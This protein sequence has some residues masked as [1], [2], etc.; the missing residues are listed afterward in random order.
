MN[1]NDILNIVTVAEEGS[2]TQASKKLFI[3]QSAIS[4]SVA[5][6]ERELGVQLFIR[7]RNE[8][9]KTKS[10]DIFVTNGAEVLR[11]YNRLLKDM[12]GAAESG[13]RKL[14][15]GTASFFFRFLTYHSEAVKKRKV[16]NFDF[17]IIEETAANIEK[18]VLNGSVD[19]CFTRF[20]LLN[21]GLEYEDLF[22]ETILIAVPA[23]HPIALKHPEDE[24]NR[25]P[26]LPLSDFKD[27]PFVMINNPRITPLCN[28]LCHDAGFEPNVTLRTGAWEHVYAYIKTGNAVGFI[29]CLHVDNSNKQVRFFRID[30]DNDYLKHVVAYTANAILPANARLYINEFRNFIA[31]RMPL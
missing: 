14:R 29:S 4:Q 2:F 30:S 3:S 21:T 18:M 10:C 5:K 1:I 26:I 12:K 8:I 9:H 25:F 31:E 11:S 19:F 6:V 17:E 20:P 16:F 15:I 24:K 27:E 7:D 22:E 13:K 23:N 28:Q